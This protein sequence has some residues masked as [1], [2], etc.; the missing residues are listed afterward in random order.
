MFFRDFPNLILCDFHMG[1]SENF[2]EA[3]YENYAK[4]EPTLFKPG[5]PL[6]RYI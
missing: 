1:G 5:A 3:L 2:G 4:T 6:N